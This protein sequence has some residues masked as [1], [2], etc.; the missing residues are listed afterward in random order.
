MVRN[1]TPDCL[2]SACHW[3]G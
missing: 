2:I 3:V 1:A